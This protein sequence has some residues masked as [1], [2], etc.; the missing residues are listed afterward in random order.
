[1][2][3]VTPEEAGLAEFSPRG[4][5]EHELQF[6]IAYYTKLLQTAGISISP[7]DIEIGAVEL[8]DANSDNR[9]TVDSSGAAS[10]NQTKI[11]GT[12]V[13]VNTGVMDN[14][15]Q[16]VTLA[17]DGPG[18]AN[19]STIATNTPTRSADNAVSTGSPDY[20][21]G[22]AVVGASYAPS[23]TAGDRAI[24]PMDTVS[25]GLLCHTRTLTTTDNVTNT[26]VASALS[27]STAYEASRVVKASAGRLFTVN[28]YNSL[29]SAQFIQV[30]NASSLP[31][32]GAAPIA[33]IT[34]PASSNFSIDF[35]PLGIP[36]SVGIV[37]TNS[38]TGSTK[39]IGVANVYFT[40]SYT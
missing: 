5:S 21:G 14:G 40:V 36:C 37:V 15:T 28:G 24:F 18:V 25:G 27:S 26:P 11:S 13:S 33:V 10:V 20:V 12:A 17:T 30:H 9:Q 16:R 38:T 31:A 19:L 35:G 4:T 6:L 3:Q 1:M 34:V 29:G 22:L 32:D 7:G 8:K 2:A 39:T 23:Y